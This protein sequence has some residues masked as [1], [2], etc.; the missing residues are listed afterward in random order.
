MEISSFNI[1]VYGLVLNADKVLVSKESHAGRKFT[2]FPGGGL[3]KGE[4]LISALEREFEEELGVGIEVISHFYTTDFF[5]V[6]A[7]DESQQLL[8]IYYRVKVPGFLNLE[9]INNQSTN[10]QF[11]WVKLKEL[12]SND[13]S[14]PVDRYV[15]KLLNEQGG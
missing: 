2:K 7:F 13:L 14:F 8:S 3:E 6:S 10:E 11:S 12:N 4:G 15:I 9:S 5:Q 1:R